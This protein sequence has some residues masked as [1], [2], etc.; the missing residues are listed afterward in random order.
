[1]TAI[2]DIFA[3]EI[4]DSRGNP[5]IEVDV[6]LESGARGRAAA[7]RGLRQSWRALPPACGLPRGSFKQ[8]NSRIGPRRR[9]SVFLEGIPFVLDLLQGL[10]LGFGLGRLGGV[11]RRDPGLG[12]GG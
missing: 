1:M 2:I 12:K 8:K 10:G 3:R 7:S 5:T 11:D 4:L 9:G 6:T